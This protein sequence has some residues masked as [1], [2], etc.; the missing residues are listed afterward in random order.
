MLRLDQSDL[1]ARVADRLRALADENR[2]RLLLAL[3][4]GESP[5]GTLAGRLEINQASTS[6]HLAIL[7][8]AGLV[9]VRRSG[10]Q[11]IY[12]I[13]DEQVFDMCALVCKGVI[14]HLQSQQAVLDSLRPAARKKGMAS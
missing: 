2:I 11:S 10:T 6:K 5:V 13:K 8:A 4:E 7:K 1:I 12:F 14:S 9:D 3:K